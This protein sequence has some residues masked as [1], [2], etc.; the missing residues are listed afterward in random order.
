MYFST[1]ILSVKKNCINLKMKNMLRNSVAVVLVLILLV[2]CSTTK[3]TGESSISKLEGSWQLNYI[4]GPRIAFDGLYPN[5]KPEISFDTK[6]STLS[7]NN[8]CNSFSGKLIVNQGTIDFTQ[9]MAMTK[10][11]C[12]DTQQGENVFMT[13]LPKINKYTVSED[14]KTLTLLSADVAMMR[15]IKQ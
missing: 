12:A 7:G 15:F 4:T 10:M 6:N 5:K 11:M 8:S 14:G 13:T 3:S 2:S 1:K 9:P